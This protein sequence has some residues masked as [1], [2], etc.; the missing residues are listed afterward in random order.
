VLQKL[1]L[2][3]RLVNWAIEL[4]E[5]DIQYVSWNAIKG[6]A[7]VDFL[8]EF[9]N[10]QEPEV[11]PKD[12][13]WVIYVDGSSTKKNG[14]DGILLVTPDGKELTSFLRLEFQTTNNEGEAVLAGLGLA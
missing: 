11:W 5:F 8:A 13:T 9:T 10:M 6:Q 1:D 7:L 2:S 12:Q 4:S 3:G 14:G